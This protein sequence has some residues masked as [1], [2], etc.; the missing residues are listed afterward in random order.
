MP[1]FQTYTPQIWRETIL[2]KQ[3][4]YYR[5]DIDLIVLPI[6]VHLCRYLVRPSI[7]FT[8]K[9]WRTTIKKPPK[10]VIKQN[11]KLTNN[12]STINGPSDPIHD[13]LCDD[14]NYLNQEDWFR[15]LQDDGIGFYCSRRFSMGKNPKK[16]KNSHITHQ[17]MHYEQLFKLAQ[18]IFALYNAKQQNLFR[19]MLKNRSDAIHKIG[20]YIANNRF[21]KARGD[22]H[23]VGQGYNYIQ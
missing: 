12:H 21:S 10:E 1:I 23:S 16:K 18:N 11:P 9:R 20:M 3:L 14:E 17:R 5:A 4:L 15:S 8:F 19:F 13:A 7:Q 6:F 22:I 2:A